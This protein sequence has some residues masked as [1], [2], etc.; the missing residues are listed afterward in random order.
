M[1]CSAWSESFIGDNPLYNLWFCHEICF[2]VPL[3][4]TCTDSGEKKIG[5]S[6][7]DVNE[8]DNSTNTTVMMCYNNTWLRILG[9]W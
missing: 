5:A 8:E 3:D 7:G 9:H 2:L 4:D 1:F 6:V